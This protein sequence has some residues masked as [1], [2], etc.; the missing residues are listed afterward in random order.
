MYLKNI[1]NS[2]QSCFIGEY[3]HRVTTNGLCD[4]GEHK[5]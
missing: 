5:K 4:T 2:T 3:E 1:N